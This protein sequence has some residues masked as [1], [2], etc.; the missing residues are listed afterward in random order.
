MASIRI[1]LATASL[2]MALG[3]GPA[4]GSSTKPLPPAKAVK[5]AESTLEDLTKDG[6]DRPSVYEARIGL[7]QALR[8]LGSCD[9][10]ERIDREL[11]TVTA[12]IERTEVPVR[13]SPQLVYNE[14]GRVAQ[15]HADCTNDE[16]Q[17]KSQHEAA[18][19]A[20]TLARQAAK[21]NFDA[22][23]EA[24]V[25][26]N[27][28][29]S[30]EAL[31]DLPQ[32]IAFMEEACA[33]DLEY[34]LYDNYQEDYVELVRMRDARS[35]AETPPESVEQHLASVAREK[36]RFSFKPAHGDQQRY[37]SE[38]RQLTLANG[39]RQE[40]KLEMQYTGV[41]ALKDDLVTVTIQ[42]GESK[43]NGR[44]AKL[45]AAES[46][47]PTP[48]DLVARLLGRPFSYSVKTNGEF[49]GATGLDE[50]RRIVLTEIDKAFAAPAASE[51]RERA[52]KLTE[53][54]LSDAVI[55]Q[56][57]ASEWNIAVAWWVDA[58][59]DLGD[60][61]SSDVDAP[62]A[63]LEGSTLKY[64]Y[65]FK[66]NRRL[67][68]EP[69]DGKKSCVE[70][71][72]EGSP[73]REQFADHLIKMMTRLGSQQSRKQIRSFRERIAQDLHLVERN[74]L[75]VDPTTLKTYR[76]LKTKTTYMP[77]GEPNGHPKIELRTALA[78]L[79][80]PAPKVKA[81]PA[82]AKPARSADA[83]PGQAR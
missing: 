14:L 60:W 56:Q 71:I 31:G 15:I 47:N 69:S 64:T 76:H 17:Q 42:P 9:T 45:V 38:M 8:A 28:A 7:V 39:Q 23:N 66:V 26:Y 34:A 68:C 36:V 75:V 54:L 29:Q 30:A 58:E 55:N 21:Q 16:S 59:L 48:E 1:F 22:M 83:K 32:A 74:V 50:A 20:F 4:V 40:H 18:L 63:V 53:Q 78:E 35:G 25:L 80:I 11:Q 79:Q 43:V 49:V 5:A 13:L 2:S 62:Q 77:T 82:R 67:A 52:R 41:V 12:W 51:Q 73:D 61:Y 19:R 10:R 70:L 46:A 57:I 72:M 33:I 24:V 37:R 6:E 65:T 27:A 44:D 3:I 81:A